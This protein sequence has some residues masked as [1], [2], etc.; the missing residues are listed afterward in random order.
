MEHCFNTYPSASGT[1]AFQY[2]LPKSTN[3]GHLVFTGV[4][5]RVSKSILL[6][7]SGVSS[8]D[9]SALSSGVDRYSLIVVGKTVQTDKMAI[10]K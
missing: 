1:T 3:R 10:G 4:F 7:P 9:V 2:I 8:V 6:T 5:D